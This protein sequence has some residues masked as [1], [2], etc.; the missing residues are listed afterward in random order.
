MFL[1]DLP[2]LIHHGKAV[3]GERRPEQNHDKKQWIP[4]ILVLK[5]MLMPHQGKCWVFHMINK[6]HLQPQTQMWF[7]VLLVSVCPVSRLNAL[8]GKWIKMHWACLIFFL[9]FLKHCKEPRARCHSAKQLGMFIFLMHY[10]LI[11]G[12]KMPNYLVV[13]DNPCSGTRLK[14]CKEWNRVQAEV[15]RWLCM[16]TSEKQLYLRLVCG[17]SA[18]I[19]LLLISLLIV[20]TTETSCLFMCF[21]LSLQDNKTELCFLIARA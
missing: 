1:W 3:A 15:Y 17:I 2:A 5:G 16:V 14:H 18:K 19:V 6:Q 13:G 10:Y 21:F 8:N 12:K 4:L 20:E 9:F 11:V 7:L